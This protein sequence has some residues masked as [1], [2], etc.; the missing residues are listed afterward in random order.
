MTATTLEQFLAGRETDDRSVPPPQIKLS[1][2]GSWIAGTYKGSKT[3][4]Y[5]GKPSTAHLMTME[6]HDGA[7]FEIDGKPVDVEQGALCRIFGAYLN[8]KLRDEDKGSLIVVS[9]AGMAEKKKG[10]NPAKILT[11]RVVK[12]E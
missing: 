7:G 6:N 1:R 8:E 2:V 3:F 9:F 12:G 4:E 5:Q 11:V 10:K